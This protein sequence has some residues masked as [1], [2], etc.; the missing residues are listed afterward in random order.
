MV[1]FQYSHRT[2]FIFRSLLDSLG[3]VLAFWIPILNSSNNFKTIDTGLHILV[4]Q[5]S[6]KNLEISLGHTLIFCPI[7]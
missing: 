4:S 6:K 3:V 5:A 2:V 7:W 1:M